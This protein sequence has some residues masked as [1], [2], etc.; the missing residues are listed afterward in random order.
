MSKFLSKICASILLAIS[1]LVTAAPANA[2]GTLSESYSFD[3]LL[4]AG[5]AF[6]GSVS[7]G[8]ASVLENAVS[9]YGQPNGYILGQEASGAIGIGARYGEGTL[10]TRNVGQHTT[11]WQ[12]PTIGF[13]LGGDGSNVMMLVYNLP[14]VDAIYDRYPGIQGTAYMVGGVGMTVMKNENI[15]IV[16]IRAGVGAR[17]G[18][19]IGYLNFTRQPTWNV[20]E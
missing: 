14:N 17:L 19:N 4:D 13:D 11:F 2:Q 15:V 20:F 1:F 3:E 7:Q 8:L 10:Y 6:F 12:G 9:E 5:G 18:V 16:P